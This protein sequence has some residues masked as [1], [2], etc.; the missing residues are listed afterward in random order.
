[1]SFLFSWAPPLLLHRFSL[2]LPVYYS[3]YNSSRTLCIKCW[4]SSISYW[5]LIKFPYFAETTKRGVRGWFFVWTWVLSFLFFLLLWGVFFSFIYLFIYLL[6][7]LLVQ[8]WLQLIT[9]HKGTCSTKC[10]SLVW[11]SKVVFICVPTSPLN[12]FSPL[13]SS[14]LLSLLFSS[15]PSS[16]KITTKTW[17]QQRDKREVLGGQWAC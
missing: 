15:L 12:P 10:A 4:D 8:H 13:L 16:P 14:S 2:L 17:E 11:Y 9:K 1:M 7:Y 6:I 5:D 3:Y